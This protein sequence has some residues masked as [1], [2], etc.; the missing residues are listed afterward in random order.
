MCRPA[1]IVLSAFEDDVAAFPDKTLRYLGGPGDADH[2]ARKSDH[3]CGNPGY[4][5]GYAHALDTGVPDVATGMAIV[6]AYL[7]D[8]RTKYVI[9]QGWLYYPDGTIKKNSGH[10]TH[11]HRSFKPGTTFD[12]RPFYTSTGDT[13]MADAE[14][15]L[16]KRMDLIGL[17]LHIDISN[18][19][20]RIMAHITAT[21]KKEQGLIDDIDEE[22]ERIVEE[23]T[24][25]IMAELKELADANPDA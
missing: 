10:E 24:V 8:P 25:R 19:S 12:T 21:S 3:N 15:R 4:E 5:P 17:R 22:V 23:N 20:K 11:V 6:E 7:K 13:L 2:Q 18:I 1:P 9:F 14:E 16:A